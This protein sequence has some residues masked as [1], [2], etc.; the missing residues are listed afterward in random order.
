MN[1]FDDRFI[2]DAITSFQRA[3]ELDTSFAIGYSAL[4][5]AQIY[6]YESDRERGVAERQTVL[7]NAKTNAQLALRRDSTLAEPYALLGSAAVYEGR[8]K[9]AVA[10]LSKGVRLNERDIRSLTLLGELYFRHFND[11]DSARHYFSL[12]KLADPENIDCLNNFATIS[13]RKRD[14]DGAFE[15]LR[16]VLR[17]DPRNPTAWMNLGFCYERMQKYDSAAMAFE[18][19]LTF[20]RT[21][22]QVREYLAY[23]AEALGARTRAIAVLEEGVKNDPSVYPLRYLYGVVCELQGQHAEARRQ[24]QLG[25]QYATNDAAENPLDAGAFLLKALFYARLGRKADVLEAMNRAYAVYSLNSEIAVGF[26]RVY[27][28]LNERQPMLDWF[29]LAKSMSPVDCDE[30]FVYLTW[31]FRSF[32]MDPELLLVARK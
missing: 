22:T 30:A 3:I 24:F 32:R 4:A 16:E 21:S 27:A 6:D 2:P 12:A 8:R 18:K 5:M 26:A 29:R 19:A 7:S 14:F 28:V 20:D 17:R 23:S 31:D 13:V 9:D 11:F 10:L 1:E 25:L 15:I